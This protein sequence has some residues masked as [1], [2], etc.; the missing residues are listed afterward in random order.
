MIEQNTPVDAVVVLS[1][2]EIE[3]AGIVGGTSPQE[4]PFLCCHW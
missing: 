1:D 4:Q 2:D 3:I